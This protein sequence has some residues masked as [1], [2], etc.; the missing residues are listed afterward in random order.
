MNWC[1]CE[2]RIGKVD[3]LEVDQ[4][5]YSAECNGERDIIIPPSLLQQQIQVYQTAIEDYKQ[6]VVATDDRTFIVGSDREEVE[7]IH[8]G[9]SRDQVGSEELDDVAYADPVGINN[10]GQANDENEHEEGEDDGDDDDD[11]D[12]G[13][14]DVS[15]MS[16]SDDDDAADMLLE[17]IDLL[18]HYDNQESEV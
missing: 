2:S 7:H 17:A 11:A 12:Y 9:D 8:V 3:N 10:S 1:A 5:A 14:H 15:L 4:V 16:E 18:E 6:F 13:R